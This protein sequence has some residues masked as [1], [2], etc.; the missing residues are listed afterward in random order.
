MKTAKSS[1]QSLSMKVNNNQIN[2]IKVR[3]EDYICLTDM[4]KSAGSDRALHSWLRTKNT[5][6]FLGFWE[7]LNNPD[8]KIHEFVHFKNNAGGNSFNPSITEWIEKTNA[9]GIVTRRGRYG[10]TYAHKDIAFEFGTWLS[11]KFKL[12][13]ITEFQRLKAKEQEQIEWDSHRYLS[14]VNYRLHTE[15]IKDLLLPILQL[16]KSKEI[17]IYTDEADILNIIVF[18]QTASEWRKNN[19]ELAKSGKNQRDFASVV[20]L[21][22]LANLES[23]NAHLIA[24]GK[25]R[26]ER[27]KTLLNSAEQQ[28]KSLLRSDKEYK[29]LDSDEEDMP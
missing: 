20:Q 25:P 12:L 16:T 15:A 9:I 10:G 11:P 18:G 23:L 24:E 17:F 13:I 14:R 21:I 28:Y 3:G 26:K 7:Q 2:L 8:F 1:S 27:I 5:L 6:E 22:V 4:A 19:T 29:M